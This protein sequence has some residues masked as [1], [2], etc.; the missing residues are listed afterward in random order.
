ME[1][2][3]DSSGNVCGGGGIIYAGFFEDLLRFLFVTPVG[4]V[5]IGVIVFGKVMDY[6]DDYKRR[7][8]REARRRNPPA[9]P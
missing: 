2:C 9:D 4:Y 6:R 3:Y 8:E 1:E 7:V 5:I